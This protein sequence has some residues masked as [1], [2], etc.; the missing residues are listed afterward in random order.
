MGCCY[1]YT[2]VN[3]PKTVGSSQLRLAVAAVG[4]QPFFAVM[5]KD[6]PEF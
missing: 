2:Y 3:S 1:I 6:T 4:S 5:L